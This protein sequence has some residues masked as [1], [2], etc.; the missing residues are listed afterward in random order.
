VDSP[1]KI[2]AFLGLIDPIVHDGLATVEKAD[3]RFYRARS[4]GTAQ[5]D[6]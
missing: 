6:R 3:V 4:E 1:E 2:E 5:R